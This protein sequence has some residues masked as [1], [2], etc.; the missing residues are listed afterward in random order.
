MIIE[1]NDG[2]RNGSFSAAVL[3]VQRNYSARVERN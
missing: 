2:Y 3:Y 1:M